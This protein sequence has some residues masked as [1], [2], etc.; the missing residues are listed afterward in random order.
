ML[1]SAGALLPVVMGATFVL[2]PVVGLVS[3][4]A[5]I[6]TLKLLRWGRSGF[7]V[8]GCLL[9]FFTVLTFVTYGSLSRVSSILQTAIPAVLVIWFFNRGAVKAQF[10]LSRKHAGKA[11]VPYVVLAICVVLLGVAYFHCTRRLRSERPHIFHIAEAVHRHGPGKVIVPDAQK[12]R[13][14]LHWSMNLP[15]E[16]YVRRFRRYGSGERSWILSNLDKN[17]VVMV[18]DETVFDLLA[19]M[20]RILGFTSSYEFAKR[21][22]HEKVGLLLLELKAMSMPAWTSGEVYFPNWY[23]VS[24]RQSGEKGEIYNYELWHRETMEPASLTFAVKQGTITEHQVQRIVSSLVLTSSEETVED[25]FQEGRVLF[26][27]GRYLEATYRFAGALHEDPDNAQCHYYLGYALF[28]M[29]DWCSAKSALDEA[30]S[31]HADYPEALALLGEV[32][33]K[34]ASE[35]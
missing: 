30:V 32:E 17:V 22:L 18:S 20:G 19:G 8:V 27:E 26:D 14:R 28:N 2:G 12:P 9:V 23:G 13:R 1:P 15:S 34:L 33:G 31:L 35:E 7:V 21:L 3:I 29:K 25:Y 10:G 16:L 24:G 5:G 4:V 6:G 11:I